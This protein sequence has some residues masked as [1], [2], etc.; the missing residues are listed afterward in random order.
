M[1]SEL[2][3]KNMWSGSVI[4]DSSTSYKPCA[5]VTSLRSYLRAS[6]FLNSGPQIGFYFLLISTGKNSFDAQP[7]EWDS[8][9]KCGQELYKST[10]NPT[11]FVLINSERTQSAL[12]THVLHISVVTAGGSLLKSFVGRSLC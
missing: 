12:H 10:K 11:R 5:E 3:N 4:Y 2:K 1:F 8:A 9:A 6:G 7:Q